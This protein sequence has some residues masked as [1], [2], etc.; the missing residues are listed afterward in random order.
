MGMQAINATGYASVLKFQHTVEAV[1]IDTI[2]AAAIMPIFLMMII[3]TTTITT[4]TLM[5]RMM[6]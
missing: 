4:I 5:I 2:A 6:T 1:L 3:V